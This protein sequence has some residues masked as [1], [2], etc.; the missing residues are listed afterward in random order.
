MSNLENRSEEQSLNF[1]FDESGVLSSFAKNNWF[2]YGGFYYTNP[3]KF[4]K[5]IEGFT[6]YEREIKDQFC[7]FEDG[8]FK[9]LFI[10]NKK[11]NDPSKSKSINEIRTLDY[12]DCM[13]YPL[14]IKA[15]NIKDINLKEKIFNIV[16][17]SSIILVTSFFKETN[18]FKKH[19]ILTYR[20]ISDITDIYK[21]KDED[22]NKNNNDT[23]TK[24][25]KD[26]NEIT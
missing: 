5:I 21:N 14:E 24:I 16:F 25:K 13:K 11:R 3:K 15:S 1:Y 8:D 6:E 22:K 19:K 10:F 2:L 12:D 9:N 26:Y 4:R 17:P 20:E 23:D 7:K 18:I